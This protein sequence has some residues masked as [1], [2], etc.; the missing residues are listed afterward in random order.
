M[1]HNAQAEFEA[2]YTAEQN[3]RKLM[4]IYCLAIA[5]ARGESEGYSP[6]Q[7]TFPDRGDED[8]KGFAVVVTS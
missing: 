8:V 6:P 5:R 2:K 1:G 4:D 7:E 3:C